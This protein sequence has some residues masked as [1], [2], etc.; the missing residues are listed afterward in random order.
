MMAKWAKDRAKINA[1]IKV[2][3][4]EIKKQCHEIFAKGNELTLT[5]YKTDGTSHGQHD[6]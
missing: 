3:N 6:L 2:K 5:Y 4:D 1:G